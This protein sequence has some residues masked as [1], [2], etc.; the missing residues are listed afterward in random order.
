MVVVTFFQ[1]VLSHFDAVEGYLTNGAG[2]ELVDVSQSSGMG[3]HVQGLSSG[4]L[5]TVV[6]NDFT[7]LVGGH[8]EILSTHDYIQLIT[9]LI[10][11]E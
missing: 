4:N 6:R 2:D 7:T 10:L 1:F 9:G 8:D 3:E 5:S 11:D